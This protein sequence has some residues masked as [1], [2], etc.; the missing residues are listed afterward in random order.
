MRYIIY[1]AGA[2]GGV[3]GGRLFGAGIDTVLICRG[4]HLRAI[5]ERGLTLREPSGTRELRIPAVAHPRELTFAPGDVVVFSMKSQDTAA[6]LDDLEAAGGADLPIVCC[7]N[8]VDNERQAARRFARVYAMLVALPATFLDP[9][10]VLGWGVPNA[11]VLDLGCFPS[12]VDDLSRAI[13]ADLTAVGV[14][15]RAN[16]AIMRLKYAKLLN[17][18]G[19]ALE[20]VTSFYRTDESA[21]AIMRKIRSEALTCYTAAGFDCAAEDEYR[22]LVSTHY[23]PADIPGADRGGTSTWQS[24]ARGSTRLE[25]DYLNG[26]IVLLGKLHGVPT[27]YNAVV[28]RLS[29]QLAAEGG[30]PGSYSIADIEAMAERLA[31]PVSSTR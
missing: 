10:I 3:L 29:Q 1:G 5:R 17:N 30:K 16:P 22:R 8:G 26:E 6:A 14:V 21:Q 11:G 9:G 25:A 20:A 12:G 23:Q 4:T 15:S 27:P 24:L 31:A 28:R 2:I 18:I 13:A 7:Q 19:N